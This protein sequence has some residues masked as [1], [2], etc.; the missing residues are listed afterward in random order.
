MTR[1]TGAAVFAWALAATVS[2]AGRSTPCP[3]GM[4]A[5]HPAAGADA[6]SFLVRSLR[7]WPRPDS[8]GLLAITDPTSGRI[9]PYDSAL[10]V[11]ALLRAG[12]RDLAGRVVLGLAAL[13]EADGGLPFSFMLPR[14]DASR[15]YERSGAIAWVGYCAAE[16]LDAAAGGG[17]RTE[18]LTLAHR[19]AGYLL[20]RQV[21][22]AGDPRDG[23]V[24]GG[25]G[26]VYYVTAG[27][28]VS[29]GFVPGEVAWASV[30]HNVDTYF[31]LR[32]LARITNTRP[33]ADGAERIARALTSRAWSGAHGQLVQGVGEQGPDDTLALDCA[34][35][36]SIF[37]G[38][39]AE[40]PRA[41]TALAVADAR[42]ASRDPRSGASGHRPYA[43]GPVVENVALMHRFAD[44]LPAS[45]WD[46]LD[47]VWP[48]G[49][50]GV[51]LAEWRAGHVDRARAIVDALEV[52]RAKDGSLPTATVEVPFTLDTSPS[53]AG[54]AWVALV[55]FEMDRPA[56][57]PTLWP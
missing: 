14:P 28:A 17:A 47:V 7:P 36:G 48:E 29:E 24:L 19:A 56:G 23:L 39:V 57:H 54:T 27:E 6:T 40:T 25:V 37:L 26:T 1:A 3:L 10:V 18:A 34:S 46:R 11:L 9:G 45:T 30:E 15:R 22:K 12:Q 4:A 13:Q 41:D 5:A 51:A 2:C 43:A 44:K 8:Q 50:A 42:Y 20:R 38:A 53:V 21:D 55:R 49:S 35:W 16:Y 32:T 31:F 52:L 33:Y